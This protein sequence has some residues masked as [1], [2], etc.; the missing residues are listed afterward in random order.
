MTDETESKQEWVDEDMVTRESRR[1]DLSHYEDAFEIGWDG[2]P[3]PLF[4]PG[5]RIIIEKKMTLL[6]GRPWLNTIAYLVD[7]VNQEAGLLKLWNEDLQQWDLSHYVTGIQKH[8]FLYKLPKKK[9]VAQPAQP[10]P[11]T[12]QTGEKKRGRP[13]KVANVGS[14][15]LRSPGEKRG[16]GRP[17]KGF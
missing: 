12:A 11:E 15:P 4:Q 16:R 5:E 9:I 14:V 1:P 6:P 3:R 8:G 7:E 10:P 13:P 2:I 17:R